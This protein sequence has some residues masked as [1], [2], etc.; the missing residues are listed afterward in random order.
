L[1]WSK[2]IEDHY[3][4]AWKSTPVAC[5]WNKGP[6]H[7]LPEDFIVLKYPPHGGRRN[8]TY[9]T[10]CMSQP[11]DLHPLELHIFSPYESDLVV[12]LLYFTAHF[13]R[14]GAKLGL[15]HTVSFGRPWLLG[16]NC[17]YGFIS[18]PYLDD[19]SLEALKTQHSVVNFYWLVPITL[20][21]REYK[22][23]HGAE[24]LV[25]KFERWRLNPANSVRQSLV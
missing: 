20:A 22:I 6:V 10:R 3:S 19:P 14:T 1:A 11:E 25:K 13:H 23:A 9:A 24:A 5:V 15:W 2:I 17:Q 18:L 16:S 4:E 8:W 7:E 12:E 21:E